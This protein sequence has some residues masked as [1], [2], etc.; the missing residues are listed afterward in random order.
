MKCSILPSNFI[1]FYFSKLDPI[2]LEWIVNHVQRI[3]PTAKATERFARMDKTSRAEHCRLDIAASQT[4]TRGSKTRDQCD[5][6]FTQCNR[7]E[8]CSTDDRNDRIV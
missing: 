8:T 1:I 5:E 6:R 7:R 3:G 4:T 2:N